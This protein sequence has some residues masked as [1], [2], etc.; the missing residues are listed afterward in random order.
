VSRVSRT[1]AE[2][3]PGL[4]RAEQKRRRV[5]WGKRC[6][7]VEVP[8]VLQFICSLKTTRAITNRLGKLPRKLGGVYEDIY[9]GNINHYEEEDK[10]TAEAIFRWL[11]CSQRPLRSSE[12]C[13]AISLNED[14]ETLPI[15]TVLQLCCNF[16]VHDQELDVFRFAHLSVREYLEEKKDVYST[17]LNHATAANACLATLLSLSNSNSNGLGEYACWYWALHC[18]ESG[19]YLQEGELQKRFNK[20]MLQGQDIYFTRWSQEAGL[21]LS[22]IPRYD[23]QPLEHRANSTM[24]LPPHP[25]FATCSWGFTET[26]HLLL[27][28]NPLDYTRRNQKG[29]TPLYVACHYGNLRIVQRLIDEGADVNA[30]G[31]SYGN[32]LQVASAYGRD[33]IVK[34]LLARGPTLTRKEAPTAMRCR[35]HR[36]WAM[37]RSSSACSPGGPTSAR[38]EVSMATRCRRHQLMAATRSSSGYSRGGLTSTRK[39]VATATRCRRHRRMATTRSS[40]DCLPGGPTSTRKEALTATHCRR[41]RWGATTRSSNSC[42]LGGPT[43]TR[44]EAAMATRCRRH[45]RGATTKSSSGCLPGGLTL[46][47]ME[48]STATR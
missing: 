29:E 35:R 28:T 15:E 24:S 32:A 11:L 44:K 14:G 43:S 23:W 48:V 8:V 7:S 46:T 45:R 33:Q 3:E 4:S 10:I 2:V 25:I 9:A 37:T 22:K 12:F 17:T 38:M 16:V 41:H 6:A 13:T 26:L 18:A 40:S 39:G 21:L 19:T 42:S 30:Q 47:R 36:C 31:G 5:T 1:G 27:E 34:R 20:F